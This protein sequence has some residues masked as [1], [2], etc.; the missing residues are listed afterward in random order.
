MKVL[1][2][3]YEYP[4]V[5]GGG[6]VLCRDLAEGMVDRGH[7]VSVVT[8][9]FENSP[10]SEEVNGVTLHRV[11]VWMRRQQNVASM[12]SMLSYVP[13]AIGRGG[14]LLA[15]RSYDL[16]NTYFA[17]PSGPAGCYL[18]WRY[19]LPDVL[20]ILGGDI[21]DPSKSLSPHRIPFLRGTVGKMM[22]WAD[23]VV[24]EST[25]V[26]NNARR[27]Y[28]TT[29]HI[30]I[31]PLAVRPN[32]YESASRAGLGL[33]EQR[34]TLVTVGRL[35]RRKNLSEL[36]EIFGTIHG[37]IPC[38][39]LIVGEGPERKGLEEQ[40]AAMG[41]ADSVT[42]AGRVSER[43]KFELLLASDVYVSTALHEGFGIVFLEAMECGLPVVCYDRG[44][45]TDYLGN[46]ETGYVV[47][48][49]DKDT[50][51]N[52]CCFLYEHEQIRMN[53][54]SHNASYVKNFYIDKFVER[55][56]VVFDK[57]I[58]DHGGKTRGRRI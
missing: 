35:I 11:P 16:I 2:I 6:G 17:V 58:A 30:D 45:Q 26:E 10:R 39:L 42:F 44:G 53:V 40:A 41:L 4:P 15:G 18:S 51:A 7:E 54:S 21:Y 33:K 12:A 55:H 48:F 23:R 56:L 38:Q 43:R 20:H 22:Q 49:S 47:G 46:G 57:A 34:F 28:G 50:F 13:M 19:D 5:G 25:E 52:Q 14:E 24:A 36:L 32:P 9:Q 37:R 8:S 3:N 27:Y 31:I 29:R 1:M